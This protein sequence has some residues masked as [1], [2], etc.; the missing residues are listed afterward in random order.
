MPNFQIP[1]TVREDIRAQAHNR[2]SRVTAYAMG[3]FPLTTVEIQKGVVTPYNL[4]LLHALTSVSNHQRV[5][6][7]PTHATLTLLFDKS[8][9]PFLS[10]SMAFTVLVPKPI[11]LA[12]TTWNDK[13]IHS[14]KMLDETDASL[15]DPVTAGLSEEQVATLVDW[16][17]A[18][19]RQYRLSN[20]AFRTLATVLEKLVPTTAHLRARWPFLA[21]LVE[22][23]S[24]R[25][26]INTQTRGM[27]RYEM[28]PADQAKHAQRMALAETLI[29]QGD[30]LAPF[31]RDKNKPFVE[32]AWF[33]RLP[34]D[35]L[36]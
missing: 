27:M 17:N 35:V 28:L 30:I 6:T 14:V 4:E 19:L 26:K 18:A 15:F 23:R 34:N 22:D 8:L 9:L 11:F 1:G 24:W 13:G 2:I 21:T 25:N 3:R 31:E 32:L 10:R 7:I 5:H 12:R 33:E 36:E 16:A 20:L 29:T